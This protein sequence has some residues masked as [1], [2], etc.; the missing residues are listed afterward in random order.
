MSCN[1]GV[2]TVED[3]YTFLYSAIFVCLFV[4]VPQ[5]VT[6]DTQRTVQNHYRKLYAN[7]MHNL[8]EIDKFLERYNFPRLN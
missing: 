5:K 6:A 2:L 1:F 3:E 4:F 8:E 7:K